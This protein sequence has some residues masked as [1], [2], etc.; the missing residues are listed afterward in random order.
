MP[1][2]YSSI[3]A[4]HKAVRS[5]AGIFDTSHM[6]SIVVSGSGALDLL[7]RVLTQK[8]DTLDVGR[9]RYGFLL[10]HNAGFLD[11]LIVYHMDTNAWMLVVNAGT[12]PQ[13]LEWIQHQCNNADT[14]IQDLREI[15]GKMDLQGPDAPALMLRVFGVDTTNLKRFHWMYATIAGVKCVVSR[16][17]YTGED[18]FEIYPPLASMTTLWQML[19]DAEI[20]PCGLGARDT[21]RLEA[22]YSLYGNELTPDYSPAEA[23]MSRYCD[24]ERDFIGKKALQKR[25]L[26]P[27]VQLVPFMVDG[28]QSA[29][30][31]NKVKSPDGAVIGVVTSGSFAPAL[32]ISIG[33]AYID[34]NV[35]TLDQPI[36]IDNQRA[37]L[38]AR[39]VKLPFQP[40]TPA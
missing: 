21:L 8:L 24:L 39:V 22:G 25:L 3:I 12:A 31:G 34:T 9:C 16:T 6:N 7:S 19:L 20:M 38:P 17:G 11:D 4:E 23:G 1:V 13:D 29:R 2:Q 40:P 10:D 35:A 5:Q 28:R 27:L 36:L 30:G 26:N 32:A 18:G 15:Q 14:T 33:F 37:L